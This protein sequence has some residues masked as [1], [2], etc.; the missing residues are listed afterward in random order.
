MKRIMK[1]NIVF[2]LLLFIASFM[3]ACNKNK[4]INK[5]DDGFALSINKPELTVFAAPVGAPKNETFSV[6]VRYEGGE[7]IDLYEYDAEVD[8]GYLEKAIYH[9][10]FVSFDADFSK[11]IE[12]KVKKNS[13]SI[14]NVKIRP[15]IEGVEPT[16]DGNTII[17]TLTSPQK[18][19]VEINGD[20]HNNLMV[21]ANKNEDK[22]ISEN[23][24]G[25]RYFGPGVHKIGGDGKGTLY[26][27]SNQKVYIAG[28]AI[29]YGTINASNADN[30][31]I[32]GR[33]ILCGGMYTDHAYPHSS[34]KGLI[35]IS[36]STNVNI[37]G[38]TLLNTV[39]WNIHLA[40]C[41]GVV[42]DNL[43]IMGWTI[44]SDGID[45]T[46]SSNVTINDCFIRNYD[47]CISIKLDYGLG[48]SSN[49][50][51]SRNIVIQ[52]CIF[53][54]D[55]G[56]S[57]LIGPESYS[58]GDKNFENIIVRNVD[59]LYNKNYGSDW[60]KGVFAIN[61]GDGATV[62]NVTFE[63]VRVDSIGSE[64]NLIAISILQTPFNVSPGQS[65]QN[66]NFNKISLNCGLNISNFIHGY[67]ESKIVDGVHFTDLKIGGSFVK[68]AS[69]GQFNL[70]L[71]TKNVDFKLTK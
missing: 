17:F 28:G 57:V 13:G 37:N 46:C 25:V 33:G 67:D 50:R 68:N 21:F 32:M 7:W 70:N 41:D 71:F 38:I 53:W 59:I 66:I 64:T 31:S 14:L 20:L 5:Q 30:I 27:T 8:G 12:V 15:K 61:L 52:N 49:A 16:V 3:Q 9:M 10:A 65:I 35:E 63:D 26:L 60:P 19:S 62:K 11:K 40:N 18:I 44:N 43:K 54:T 55:Q 34:G 4:T 6:F 22:V 42:C 39:G 51:G 1:F 48:N 29:V 56:R 23:E 69:E 2:L 36:N 45:P 47:D 58:I 24:P